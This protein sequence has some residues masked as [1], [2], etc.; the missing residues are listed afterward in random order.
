MSDEAQL[1]EYRKNNFFRDRYRSTMKLVV[2]LGIIAIGLSLLLGYTSLK[3]E[4]PKFYATTTTGEV[5]PLFPLSQ[6]VVTNSYLLQWASMSAR[7]IYNLNFQYYENQLQKIRGNF[8]GDAWGQVKAALNKSGLLDA[9]IEKKLEMSAVVTGAPIILRQ[10][11]Y[12]G[13]YVWRVQLPM[14]V[15]Y[16]SASEQ[17]R[18]KYVVTMDISRVPALTAPKGIL[19]TNFSVGID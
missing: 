13:R 19:I 12:H 3:E 18:V 7:S 4:R 5:I 8:T 2:F 15:T 14:M 16:G 6:P 11:V 10:G 17:R 9:V 1:L